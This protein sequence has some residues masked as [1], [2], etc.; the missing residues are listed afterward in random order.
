MRP[1]RHQSTVREWLARRSTPSGVRAGATRRAF[2][3]RRTPRPCD[4]PDLHPSVDSTSPCR[5]STTTSRSTASPRAT[6]GQSS[7]S[8]RS[9]GTGTELTWRSTLPRSPSRATGS[10]TPS[11]DRHRYPS[12][13]RGLTTAGSAGVSSTHSTWPTARQPPGLSGIGISPSVQFRHLRRCRA[14]FGHGK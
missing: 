3:A 11:L 14:S 5:R 2:V 8:S 12:A 10:S 1:V 6:A 7:A 9:E 4:P 13:I